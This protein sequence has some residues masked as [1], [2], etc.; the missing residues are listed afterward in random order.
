MDE[1][2]DPIK[3]AAGEICAALRYLGDASYAILPQQVA[4]DLGDFKKK[5][6]S[7]IRS[8]VDSSVDKDIE[9]INERVAGGD[10]LREEWRQACNRTQAD[11]TGQ[12][13]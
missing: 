11:E 13:V 9:W 12:P 5:I 3:S 7:N 10:R 2:R 4:H 1:A 8:F 6:L